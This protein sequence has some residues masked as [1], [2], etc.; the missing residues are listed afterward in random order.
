M[1]ET[2]PHPSCYLVF[3]HDLERA[4]DDAC[5]QRGAEVSGVCSGK[6]S[7]RMEGYGRVFGIKFQPGGL[8]PFMGGPVAGL[9]D[10]V[11]PAGEI[12]GRDILGLAAELRVLDEAESMA[13]AA[14]A[15]FATRLPEADVNT[16]VAT[17]LVS[18]IL[19]DSEMLK[20]EGL[21]K[22]SG[23]SVRAL[24]RLFKEYVGVSPKWVIRRF[25]LHELLE[26]FHAGEGLDGA[27][28]ALDLGYADQA[29]LINDFRKLAGFTPTE[30]VR[31]AEA[32]R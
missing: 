3:E 24:Q 26:R 13:A 1:A 19:N 18:L 22:V 8:R 14:A 21:S 11:V 12:F 20:V 6:F 27:R 10:R 2:L 25:R 31:L 7:R 16:A 17:E 4:V 5:V 23:L 30:Y 15:Y 28:L 9:T 32:R 29:H